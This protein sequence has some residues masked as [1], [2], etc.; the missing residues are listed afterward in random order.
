MPR[1]FDLYNII[2]AIFGLTLILLLRRYA[3]VTHDSVLYLGQALYKHNPIVYGEDLF[4]LHGSQADYTLFPLLTSHLI[5]IFNPPSLFMIGGFIGLIFFFAASFFCLRAILPSKHSYIAW[6]GIICLPTM[7]GMISMF[8]YGESFFTPRPFAEALSLTAIALITKRKIFLGGIALLLAALLHPLQAIAASLVVWIWLTLNDR[9]WLNALWLNAIFIGLAYAKIRPFDGLTESIDAIW[10]ADIQKL[11]GQIFLTWWNQTD[12]TYL[13]FDAFILIY[14]WRRI[15]GAFN[16]WCLSSIIALIIGFTAS[17]LLV[18]TLHLVL[19]AGLQLWRVQW[20]AHWFAMASFAL[21]IYEGVTTCHFS[22][23]TLLIFTATLAWFAT[24]WLW[25]PFAALYSLWP[26]LITES[27]VKFSTTLGILLA[28][29][30]LILF[31]SFLAD[32]IILF[33]I[34]HFRLDL[35]AID[36]RILAFPP[37]IILLLITSLTIWHKSSKNYRVLLIIS[38]LLPAACIAASRWDSRSPIYKAIEDNTYHQDLFGK[39]LPPSAQVY[40]DDDNIVATW[41]ILERASYFNRAQLAGII[42]NRET[43][44]DAHQRINRMLPLMRESLGCQDRS[45]PLRDRENCRISNASMQQAC[46]NN[47]T[48]RPDYLI[49]PY[50]QATA[51]IGRWDIVDPVTNEPAISYYLYSCDS[52]T[53]SHEHPALPV[54]IKIPTT[55]AK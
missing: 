9:R 51:P 20:V 28:L 32:E 11:T 14:A 43:A 45:R 4:F 22:R 55:A 50:I 6:L 17:F 54:P 36:H 21:L 5:G 15:S 33:R 52:I 10:L 12:F 41:L 37:A 26:K 19:P 39:T 34:A 18:D 53:R 31:S 2:A 38:L 48:R 27:R 23:T 47:A 29:G 25:I 16:V 44:I 42:F 13:A 49:I 30:L 3:G 1:K 24:S 35:Y 8:N 7:Y 40:W 46:I